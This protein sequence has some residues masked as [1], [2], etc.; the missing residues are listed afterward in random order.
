MRSKKGTLI[1]IGIWVLLLVYNFVS[2]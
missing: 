2:S 1:D